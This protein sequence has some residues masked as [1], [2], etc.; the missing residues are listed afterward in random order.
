[1]S[2][3]QEEKQ[4]RK[5]EREAAEAEA[6]RTAT[7]KGRLRLALGGLVALAAIVIAVLVVS[8]ASDDGEGSAG[9]PVTSTQIPAQKET[10]LKTAAEA[11]RCE[12]KTSPSEGR[13]HTTDATKWRYKTNPPTS[14]THDPVASEEGL[15]EASNSPPLG[16]AV[17][18]LEHGRINIQ[19]KPGTPKATIDKLETLGSEKLSFGTEGYHTL[20]FENTSKM[21]AAVAATAWTQSL[22]CPA[23]NDGVYDA[24]RAFRTEYTDKGPELIE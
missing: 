17:H 16:M 23:M 12:L 19:Y 15:Y 5:A 13:D 4:R 24:I 14:G 22:S 9:D 18:A 21:D 10:N 11:A 3:R 8:G 1:M 2:S 20:V 7:R 6:A